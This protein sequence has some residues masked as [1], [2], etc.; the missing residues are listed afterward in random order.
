[1]L[2]FLNTRSALMRG[3]RILKKNARALRLLYHLINIYF[4]RRQF[5]RNKT[6]KRRELR[7]RLSYNQSLTSEISML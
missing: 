6:R 4:V 3:A 1:M 5:H 2:S 7:L